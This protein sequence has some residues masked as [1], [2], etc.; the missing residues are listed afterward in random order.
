LEPGFPRKISVVTTRHWLH[1]LGFEVLSAKK[2]C[3]VDGHE[4]ADGVEYRKGKMIGV[5]FLDQNNAPTEKAKS[6]LPS[7]F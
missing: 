2:G 6:V 3:F 4:H 1:E 7:E 5:G